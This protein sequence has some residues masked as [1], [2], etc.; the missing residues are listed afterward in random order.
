MTGQK[1]YYKIPIITKIFKIKFY[2]Y[3]R[4]DK[5]HKIGFERDTMTLGQA[6][7]RLERKR[8]Y[9]ENNNY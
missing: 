5:F 6:I 7:L 2:I 9:R 4:N 1:K 8:L 3:W